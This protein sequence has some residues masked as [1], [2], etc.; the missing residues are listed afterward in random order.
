MAKRS[1]NGA[2][3]HLQSEILN[4]LADT[5]DDEV[6]TECRNTEEM[7]AALE[8]TD[9]LENAKK[10]VVWSMDVEKMYPSLKTEEVSKLVGKALIGSGGE[11]PGPCLV[12]GFDCE[13][14]GAGEEWSTQFI[15]C[16][17]HNVYCFIALHCIC[18]ESCTCL[19]LLHCF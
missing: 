2:L 19:L 6:K 10:L 14:G 18:M 16:V 9:N 15:F 3:S 11:R 13:Q 5:L 7:L 1:P 8:Q 4:N 17:V 12:F